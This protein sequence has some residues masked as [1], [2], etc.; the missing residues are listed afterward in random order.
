MPSYTRRAVLAG[1]AGLT[2]GSAIRPLRAAAPEGLTVLAAPANSSILLA[3][4]VAG[5][6]LAVAAPGIALKTWRSPDELRAALVS[7][8]SGIVSLP[9]NVAANLRNKGLPIRLVDVVSVGHMWLLS[10]DPAVN[11]LADLRGRRVQLYFRN[12]MPDLSLRFL[13]AKAGLDPDA[14]VTLDYAG[15]AVE[16]AQLLLSGR[17]ATVLL[18]EPAASSVLL[19]A[20]EKGLAIRRAVSLQTAW[21]DLTGREPFLPLAATAVTED[22]AKAHPGLLAA[23]HAE[24]EKAAAWTAA[25]V[26]EAAALA[27]SVLGFAPDAMAAS[28]EGADIRVVPAK[29]ARPALEAFL[30]ALAERSPAIIGGKLPDDGFYSDL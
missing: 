18:N 10:S 3:R 8:Q 25:H 6:G 21:A 29:A 1:I 17:A 19:A 22:L 12:D 26:A 24:T 20:R 15:S 9:T 11:A 30:S 14:D 2:A 27:Q 5:G 4:A 23:L 7:G 16:A 13:L 28:L